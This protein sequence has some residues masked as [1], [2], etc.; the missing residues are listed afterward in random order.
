MRLAEE[1][2]AAQERGDV[3]TGRPKSLGDGKTFQPT[4][5]SLGLRSDEIHEARKLTRA[6]GGRT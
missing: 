5:Q 3:A 2:D 4:T 1:Y 6:R